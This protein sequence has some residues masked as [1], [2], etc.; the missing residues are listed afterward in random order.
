M[1]INFCDLSRTLLIDKNSDMYVFE[2]LAPEFTSSVVRKV[3]TE[4]NFIWPQVM[5]PHCLFEKCFS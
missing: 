2:K 1:S 3:Q 4:N 5:V